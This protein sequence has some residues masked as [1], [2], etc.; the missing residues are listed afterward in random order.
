MVTQFQ[1]LPL[2]AT[3]NEATEA[4]LRTSQHEFPITDDTGKV[5][6]ILTRD[7]MI[8][9]AAQV[10]RRNAGRRRD[11]G[12]HSDGVRIDAVRPGIRAH[13]AVPL[14]RTPRS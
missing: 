13:A 10:G 14:P 3:L 2:H 1:T 5:H 9:R 4:L 12:G 11:A 7:D 8:A 6:G